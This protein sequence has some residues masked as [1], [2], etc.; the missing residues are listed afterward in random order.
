MSYS[1]FK[2][3][4]VDGNNVLDWRFTATIDVTTGFLFFKKTKT[5]TIQKQY[6]NFWFFCDTGKFTSRF[7][8]E[9][10]Q[11]VF[12]SMHGKDIQNCPVMPC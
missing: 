10:L 4:R 2:L 7:K 1:N 5:R 9:E 6:G 12:E 3:I 11:R 8:V